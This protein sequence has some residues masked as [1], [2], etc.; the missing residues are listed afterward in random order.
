M[1]T[2]QIII[3]FLVSGILTTT[4]QNDESIYFSKTLKGDLESVEK[5]LRAEL[6]KEKFGVITEIDM[7][8][9]LKEKIDAD[10]MPYKILGVC[11]PKHAYEA[12][13]AEENI[14]VFLP[15]KVILKQTDDKTV[16]IVTVNPA[17]MMEIIGNERL[18]KTADEVGEKLE[19]IIQKVSMP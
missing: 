3:I 9:T 1:K 8:K 10:I 15:C 7:S 16:E 18:D 13:K 2:I 5:Q 17:R 6:K 19:M 4:A 14:G 11:S 12:L